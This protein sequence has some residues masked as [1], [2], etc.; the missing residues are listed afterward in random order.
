[1]SGHYPHHAPTH[2]R[3]AYCPRCASPLDTAKR[4]AINGFDRPTCVGCGWIYYP[5]NYAG[6]LVVVEADDS[7]VM[8]HP[9]GCD[10]E[11]PCGLPGG[12]VEFGESP[13]ECAV[14][15]VEEE[16]GLVIE[17][18]AELCRLFDYAT[19]DGNALPFGPMMQFGFVGRAV[20][21]ELREGDEG[22]AVVY[23]RGQMPRISRHRSG[24]ARVFDHYLRL[25][26]PNGLRTARPGEA[27]R[28]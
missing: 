5:P 7:L 9:P 22:P 28:G 6:A 18:T 12:I 8:I 27:N 23:S 17:L 15:E 21:G 1:M 24:S 2:L 20:G 4:D 10:P 16:T 25:G 14:R 3:Y 19:A 11:E 13:E 26:E